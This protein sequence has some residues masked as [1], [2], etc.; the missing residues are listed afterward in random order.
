MAMD[1]RK[2]RIMMAIVSLYSAEGEPV[3]SNLLCQHFDMAV[4]S[5]TLRNEMAALTRLGLLEQPHTS[6]GRVPT[7]KGYRYYV[8]TLLQNPFTLPQ[9]DKDALDAT[10]RTLDYDPEKMA[11]GAAK[12]L[13]DLLGYAVIATTPQADDMSIAHFEVLQVGRYTAAVLAVTAAGGVRT[14][15]AK[16]DF[17]LAEGDAGAIAR[18]LNGHLRFVAEAD[19]D[20]ALIRRMVDSLGAN[21][22]RSWPL[23]SAA[24]TL[25]GEVGRPNIYFEGQKHLL[26]WPELENSLRPLIETLDD[27]ARMEKLLR[28][29]SGHT[30]VLFG[31]EF[32][33]APAPGM[34]LVSRQYLAGG[35]LSGVIAVAGPARMPYREVIPRLEYFSELLGQG[36]SGMAA[37]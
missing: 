13:S 28:P 6:A 14:R 30:T 34:C 22:P 37:H 1:D 20:S 7:A 23:L 5:A 25:L 16:V 21:G 24:L 36:M 3:G 10:F 9:R 8:D 18:V 17:E 26:Q 31:D 19:V 15:V 35:G 27:T 2:Q 29:R 4:S 32:P 11:Q 33:E 12:A